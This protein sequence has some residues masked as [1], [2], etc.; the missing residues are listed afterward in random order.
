M[1]TCPAEIP[2]PA[3]NASPAKR[4]AV[5]WARPSRIKKHPPMARSAATTFSVPNRLASGALAKVPVMPPNWNI[6]A[7]STALAVAM[8]KLCSSDGSQELM[9]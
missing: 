5:P 3:P 6:E 1:P 9:E 2:S 8:P 4:S 7:A